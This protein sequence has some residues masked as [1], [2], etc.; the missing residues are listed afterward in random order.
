MAQG[1]FIIQKDGSLVELSKHPYESEALLQ[2]LLA[3]YPN[4]LCGDNVGQESPTRWLLVKRE[5]GIPDNIEAGDRWSLDHLFLDTKGIPT[6]VEVKRSSDS[7]IRREV[8]AQMLDYAANA[9]IHWP[10]DRIQREFETTVEQQGED[11]AVV[12][13]KFLGP[14]ADPDSFWQIVKTNLQAG[15]IRLVFVADEIPPELRHIVEFLNAQMDPAEVLAIEV[16]QYTGDG[17][18]TLVP[19]VLGQSLNAEWRKKSSS[20]KHQWDKDSFFTVFENRNNKKELN[21][22]LKLYS[23][24]E[25]NN[26]RMTWG[27]GAQ[28]GSFFP[29][30]DYDGKTYYT[31]CLWSGPKNPYIQL[32][33]GTMKGEF[34][35]MGFRREL[36]HRI[37][38]ATG[39]RITDEY[40]KKY[41]GIKLS[42]L[43]EQT[44]EEFIKVFDWYLERC[45]SE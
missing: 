35:S 34:E 32:Q 33:F 23:W 39:V 25:I 11:S 5:M 27:S 6:L 18:T 4:L 22:A 13:Q 2:K 45:R 38:K 28:A 36:A 26:L 42:Q 15:R 7:R 16:Q 20:D 21:L 8:V 31:F 10:I 43:T 3:Q 29:M 30:Y 40:L 9:I 12:L 24:A 44:M 17:I 41:P 37:Q 19:H 14:D 1:I